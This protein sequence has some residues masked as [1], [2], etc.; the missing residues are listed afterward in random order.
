MQ[1]S[2][3][4]ITLVFI[5]QELFLTTYR[6]PSLINPKWS[7][8]RVFT[9]NENLELNLTLIIRA[10]GLYGRILTVAVGTLRPNAARSIHMIEIKILPYTPQVAQA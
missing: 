2:E 8:Y 6:S 1:S 10:G 9:G 5:Q 4:Q 3:Y 7:L